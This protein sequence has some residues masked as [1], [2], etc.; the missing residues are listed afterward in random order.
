MNVNERVEI[1]P[2]ILAA[3]F[4]RLGEEI[5]NVEPAVSM[6]HVDVMDGHYVPNLT[7]GVPVIESIRKITSL[8]FDVHLMVVDPLSFVVP[9]SE[10]GA[11]MITLHI[12]TLSDPDQGIDL[13]HSLGKKAGLSVH[14]DTAVETLFP[15][16]HKLDR[17]LV[18]SVRPGF[19][20]QEFMP[21]ALAR[22]AA[23]RDEI[24]KIGGVAKIAVDGGITTGN[25]RKI[26]EAGADVLVVGSAIFGT[27]N[28]I[29]AIGEFDQCVM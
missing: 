13:I 17:V 21:E 15:Y 18:M 29:G 19:G 1:A 22:V 16:L 4:S 11:D 5:K 14:P 24:D 28:P 10:A 2:S 9:F 26:A 12:E 3:D 6:I 7:I 25:A 20:G 23:L 8:V 27:A